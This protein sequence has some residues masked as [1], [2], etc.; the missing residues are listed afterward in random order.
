[1]IDWEW[2]KADEGW[3]LHLPVH[4]QMLPGSAGRQFTPSPAVMAKD[5]PCGLARGFPKKIV[6][7]CHSQIAPRLL[8]SK[9]R[10]RKQR[11]EICSE[12]RF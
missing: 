10:E 12:N 5:Y 9:Q 3:I 7:G 11:E 1:M 6:S 4:C 8:H 2:R